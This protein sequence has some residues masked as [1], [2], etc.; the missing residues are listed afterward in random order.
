VLQDPV[1][2]EYTVDWQKHNFVFVLTTSLHSHR[3]PNV[4]VS[5]TIFTNKASLSCILV[6][7][8]TDK[9]ILISE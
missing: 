9:F 1:L 5:K 2:V 6:T 8:T 4:V 7:H 3:S